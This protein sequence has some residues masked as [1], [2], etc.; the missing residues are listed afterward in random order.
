[1]TIVQEEAFGPVL[2]M[3]V[4]DSEEDAVRLAN[5]SEYGLAA[6]IWTRDVDRPL[7]VARSKPAPSGLT[8]GVSLWSSSNKADSSEAGTPVSTVMR[9]STTF[10][11]TNTLCSTLASSVLDLEV[12]EIAR[13]NPD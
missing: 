2:T 7:R 9:G 1:M 6:S 8:I 10:W 12:E 11:S 13:S 5:D 4:F 3:M